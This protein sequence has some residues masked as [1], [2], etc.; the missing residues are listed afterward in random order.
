M[1]SAPLNVN[2]PTPAPSKPTILLVEDQPLTLLGIKMSLQDLQRYDIVGEATNGID[3]VAQAKRLH[4]DVIL[5]DV[6]L[7]GMDGIEASWQIKQDH[8]R[9]KIVMFTSHHGSDVVAASL[10]AGAEA[11]LLKDRS[12][13]QIAQAIDTV[14]QGKIWIDPLVAD[15]VVRDNDRGDNTVRNDVSQLSP[16]ELNVLKLIRD[17]L[18]NK[19]IAAQLRTSEDAVAALMRGLLQTFESA[20]AVRQGPRRNWCH[21]WCQSSPCI[22][23]TLACYRQ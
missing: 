19:T 4:P 2:R 11:Y 14:F 18:D 8:P 7:P 17:G 10:G 20:R 9:T 22:T 13:E 21:I 3:A 15:R 6:S 5:M 12:V 23:H 16:M 1:Y